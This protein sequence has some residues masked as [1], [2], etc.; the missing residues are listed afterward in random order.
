MFFVGLI[1]G[2]FL[3]FVIAVLLVAAGRED[4]RK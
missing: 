3:G 2:V 1:I 4:D